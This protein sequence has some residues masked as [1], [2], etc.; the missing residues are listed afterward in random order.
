MW[1]ERGLR[2][3]RERV[4]PIHRV[5]TDNVHT[6]SAVRVLSHAN[7]YWRLTPVNHE[8]MEMARLENDTRPAVEEVAHLIMIRLAASL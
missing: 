7:A 4:S 6:P 1:S 2:Y 3:Y 5:P 8:A